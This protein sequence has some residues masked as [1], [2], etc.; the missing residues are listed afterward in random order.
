ME[1]TL[2]V[3]GSKGSAIANGGDKNAGTMTYSIAGE[4]LIIIRSYR[5]RS[6]I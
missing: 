6:S 4:D 3:S 2:K 1:I 5:C